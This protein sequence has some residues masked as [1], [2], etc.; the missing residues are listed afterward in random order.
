MNSILLCIIALCYW[1][2][3]ARG[4][5]AA[6]ALAR[7][8]AAGQRPPAASCRLPIGPAR[9]AASMSLFNRLKGP[10]YTH[11]QSTLLT[12]APASRPVEKRISH[13][14]CGVWRALVCAHSQGLRS[15]QT[16]RPTEPSRRSERLACAS[17]ERARASSLRNRQTDRHVTLLTHSPSRLPVVSSTGYEPKQRTYWGGRR[18]GGAQTGGALDRAPRLQGAAHYASWRAQTEVFLAQRGVGDALR[19]ER[20]GRRVETDSW[21]TSA[22]RRG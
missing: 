4:S 10:A 5:R 3:Y 20:H 6:C 18:R 15:A 21:H 7:R 11:T 9:V 12:H 22:V 16:D 14:M 2:A 13:S 19:K 8:S 1:H 17:G